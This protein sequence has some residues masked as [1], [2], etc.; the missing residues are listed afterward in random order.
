MLAPWKKSYDKHSVLKSRDFTLLTKVHIVKAMVFPVVMYGCESWTIK[1][2]ECQRTDAFKLWC[3]RR[4][5][6]PL[7]SKQF[8]PVDSKGNQPWIFIGRLMLKLQYFGHLMQR[9]DSLEKIDPGKY[10]RKE[11]KGARE[12]ERVGLHHWLNGLMFEQA[13][14]ESEGQG[15][16]AW[17]S[18]WA[19][20]ESDTTWGLNNKQS[21][22]AQ[23][24]A[25]KREHI[26][27]LLNGRREDRGMK[28]WL[29]SLTR[30]TL[31]RPSRPECSAAGASVVALWIP[32]LCCTLE[33]LI[34]TKVPKK[35]PA[36][37]FL[38]QILFTIRIKPASPSYS[39]AFYS[40]EINALSFLPIFLFF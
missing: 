33:V 31:Q 14:R 18:P 27:W 37:T 7:A 22:T 4:L 29:L 3:W 1:K 28:A 23:A 2:V 34:S 21:L 36:Y 8:K 24:R 17:C 26:Q 6:S 16:L 10:W 32:V 12:D 35:L 25:P 9:A 30:T 20:K 39:W 15:S 11:A 38:S 13:L 40:W 5:E 19:H